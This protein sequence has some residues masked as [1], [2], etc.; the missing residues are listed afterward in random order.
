MASKNRIFT[1]FAFEDRG[2]RAL[3]VGQAR[4]ENSP[5]EFVDMSA[6]KPW[7]TEWKTNC[8]TRI[9][10]CDGVVGI[11]TKNS[12]QASGQLWE[13]QC[14]IDEGIPLLLIKG[15]SDPLPDNFPDPIKGRRINL[16]TWPNIK[17][18]LD[19]L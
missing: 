14:A 17:T 9:K 19:K 16:W 1:S 4:N 2:L 3:L 8:R 10:G 15:T 12:V 11:V 18:F 13:L 7:D 5:F 6:K